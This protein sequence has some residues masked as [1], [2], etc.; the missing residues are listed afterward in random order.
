MNEQTAVPAW[1]KVV[2]GLA[3][4]WN[5]VGVLAQFGYIFGMTDALATMGA[6]VILPVLVIVISASLVWLSFSAKGKGWLV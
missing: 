1:F 4:A 3:I 2:T 5:L 6:A